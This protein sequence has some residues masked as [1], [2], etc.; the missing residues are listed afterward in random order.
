[1]GVR[2]FLPEAAAR[3]RAIAEELLDE[4]ERWGYDRIITPAFEYLDVLE[5]G[6]GEGARAAA[7]RFV[8]PATGEVVALR[9][10]ITPQVARLAATR[11]AGALGPV[12][13]CYE[14]SVLRLA[15]G[16][17][18]QR[19]LIQAGIE[20]LDAPAPAGDA[21]VIALADAALTAAGLPEVTLEVSHVALLRGA[22]AAVP[23]P[24]QAR[25]LEAHVG[26]K[27]E[28]AVG[29]AAAIAGMAPRFR[30]ILTALPTLYGE[31]A[32]VLARARALPLDAAMRAAV[33]ELERALELVAAQGGAAR[34]RVDLGEVRG[35]AYYTGV[36]FAGYVPGVGDAV[37][38]G[39]RYDDLVGRYGRAA[40]ATGFAVDV[41]AI[42]QGEH[43]LGHDGARARRGVLV[44]GTGVR[45]FAVAA[46]LRRLG[47][48][49][50]VDPVP[51]PA[52]EQRAYAA[53]SG[54]AGVLALAARGGSWS[55]GVAARAVPAEAITAAV[56]GDAAPL[57]RALDLVTA[58]VGAPAAPAP[59]A[60]KSSK[61]G[62]T[63]GRRDHR[64]RPVG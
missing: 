2:D 57:V 8:E 40:R 47:V 58:R 45:P 60:L 7:L 10:D 6:M 34:L 23:D 49:A 20:L 3:R 30:R 22:L 54:A 41:E 51:R 16:A 12:R 61:K 38:R 46:A 56:A 37:L 15:A 59:A 24:T 4:F 21:E 50:S 27:D 63:D 48:R 39:G 32:A 9:P 44:A 5:R 62:A 64:R 18:G 13:L 28:D 26:R 36:R 14:G 31:P 17:R 43:A 11:L 35:F 55:N 29:A 33:D 42:A 52:K 25:E 19:E 1:V 53:Q